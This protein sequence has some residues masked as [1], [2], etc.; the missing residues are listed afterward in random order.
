MF[1]SSSSSTSWGTG[2][3]TDLL[4]EQEKIVGGRGH[5][6]SAARQGEDDLYRRWTSSYLSHYT[7]INAFNRSYECPILAVTSLKTLDLVT[8]LP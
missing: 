1:M 5:P 4:A 6:D 7:S 8:L 3:R 2:P